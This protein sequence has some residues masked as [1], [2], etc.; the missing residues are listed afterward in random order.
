MEKTYTKPVMEVT[1]FKTDD[2]IS[3]S[4]EAGQDI[5]GGTAGGQGSSIPFD[6]NE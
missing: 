1:E 6:P 2:V 5:G 4:E 3:V